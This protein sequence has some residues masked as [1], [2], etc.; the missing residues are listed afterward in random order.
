MNHINLAAHLSGERH[1]IL[2][3]SSISEWR[4]MGWEIHNEPAA[5]H[6][7]QWHGVVRKW[8]V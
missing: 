7:V 1:N 8:W 4:P 2:R 6:G 5:L 3:A